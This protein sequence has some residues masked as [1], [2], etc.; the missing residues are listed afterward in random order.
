MTQK[1]HTLTLD[2]RNILTITAV[3]DVISFDETLV[4]LSVGENLLNISG[5]GLSIKN[6]SLE[7]GDVSVNGNIQAIVYF[8]DSPKKKRF[9]FGKNR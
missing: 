2:S 1:K 5:E 6:L 3:D 4:S 7:N 8:D 9:S